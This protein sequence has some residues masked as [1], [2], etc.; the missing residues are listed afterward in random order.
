MIL[1]IWALPITSSPLVL[2]AT[3]SIILNTIR[4]V[5]RRLWQSTLSALTIA[6]ELQILTF[7]THPI[8]WSGWLQS[9]FPTTGSF[10]LWGFLNYFL[11][12]DFIVTVIVLK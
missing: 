5:F 4:Q 3:A 8:A 10:F 6:C 2:S 11:F 9:Q 12:G 7:W 1:A